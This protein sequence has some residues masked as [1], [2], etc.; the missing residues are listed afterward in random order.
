MGA[1]VMAWIFRPPQL[2]SAMLLSA[3]ITF[4]PILALRFRPK[5]RPTVSLAGERW[6]TRGALRVHQCEAWPQ[7]A[8]Q[9]SAGA[10]WETPRRGAPQAD[11]LRVDAGREGRHTLLVAPTG[12][13]KGLWTTT[14]LLT[15]NGSAIVNDLKADIYPRTAGWRANLGP[16]YVLSAAVPIHRFDPTATAHTEDDL[17]PLAFAVCYDPEDTGYCG[18]HAGRILLALM[19]AAKQS[20]Q[21]V[22]PFVAR[23]IRAGAARALGMLAE[24]DPALADRVRPYGHGGSGPFPSAWETLATR[25]NS[26]LSPAPSATMSGD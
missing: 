10:W 18:Q 15:W 17:R 5:G 7:P 2:L 19:L 22:F 8:P 13:G 25:C 6:A 14:Q 23:A 12:L 20:G 9:V 1:M 4:L 11:C 3:C 26:L 24:V 16:V 21:P